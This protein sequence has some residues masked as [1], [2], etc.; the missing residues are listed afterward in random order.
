MHEMFSVHTRSEEIGNTTITCHL[1]LCLGKPRS[2]KS[3]D[4]RDVMVSK[5]QLRFQNVFRPREM[6]RFRIPPDRKA[7]SK[8][9][10]FDTD[11]CSLSY[12]L[13]HVFCPTDRQRARCDVF[14][15]T[16]RQRARCN[17]WERKW[18]FENCGKFIMK[19]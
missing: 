5:R 2:G 14:C 4:Y 7:F 11:R 3:R 19:S 9:S 16:D 1:G 10:V 15:P 17:G 18:S 8:T 13:R 6:P 12:K